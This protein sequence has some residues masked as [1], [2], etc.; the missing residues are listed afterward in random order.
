MPRNRLSFDSTM[1][2]SHTWLGLGVSALL[3]CG[4]LLV[5]GAV[6]GHAAIGELETF[7]KNVGAAVALRRHGTARFR[8]YQVMQLFEEPSL[9]DDQDI[10]EMRQFV[11]CYAELFLMPTSAPRVTVLECSDST[12]LG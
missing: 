4:V 12:A 10:T 9:A 6:T 3:N 5:K 8:V 1:P 7:F 2:H 11:Y